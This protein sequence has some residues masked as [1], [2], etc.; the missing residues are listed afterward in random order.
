MG[1]ARHFIVAALKVRGKLNCPDWLRPNRPAQL[2]K[3][4]MLDPAQATTP[5]SMRLLL[6]ALH[7]AI[8]VRGTS[9]REVALS[10]GVSLSHLESCLAGTRRLAPTRLV[11]LCRQLGIEFGVVA[12]SLN[13]VVGGSRYL[14]MSRAARQ[15]ECSYCATVVQRGDPYVRLEPF[16]PTR[17][18]G[19]PVLH[20]CRSCSAQGSWLPEPGGGQQR[21][22]EHQLEL[23]LAPNVKTTL[24]QLVDI[25]QTLSERVL[26]D[27]SEL[28]NLSPPQFEEL[29][30]ERLHAMGLCA[31]LV[32]QSTYS[33]DG[34]IDIIFTPPKTFPFPFLGAV[35]VK[36]HG[37]RDRKVGPAPVRELVGAMAVQRVFAAGMVVTNTSFTPDAK[38]LA[39]HSHGLLK[40]RGFD[41]LVRWVADNFT[42]EAEWREMPSSIELCKGVLIDVPR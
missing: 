33:R 11:V 13:E 21:S 7:Q 2:S 35:Q 36:H 12:T 18:A 32:G 39:R 34:G 26:A 42:D 41:D 28:F 40:L 23:P 6:Q 38:D 5:E 17:Q 10:V 20:F 19:A 31:Q 14:R 3:L 22:D 4:S 1:E 15:Y 37:Q 8:G 30:L 9:T 25:G 24:V 27:S 29:V 16:G